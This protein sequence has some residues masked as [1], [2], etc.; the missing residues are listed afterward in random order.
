MFSEKSILIDAAAEKKLIERLQHIL[1]R[2]SERCV[3]ELLESV[4]KPDTLPSDNLAA[5]LLNE[6]CIPN[7]IHLALVYCRNAL[8]MIQSAGSSSFKNVRRHLAHYDRMTLYLM[9]AIEEK[10]EQSWRSLQSELLKAG[11]A[12]LLSRAENHWSQEREI[13][14][15]SYYREM[16]ISVVI[17]LLHVGESGFTTEKK[18]ELVS[19][20]SASEDGKS[21]SARMPRSELSVGLTVED[22]TRKTV[23]WRYGEVSPLTR[24]KRRDIRVQSSTPIHI[25]LKSSAQEE[26]GG[27]VLDIS[28]NGLG[29]SCMCDG[30]FQVG[31]ILIFSMLLNGH[32]LTGKGAVCWVRGGDGHCMAGLAIEHSQENHLRLGNEVLRRQKNLMAE[33]KMKGIP[34]CLTPG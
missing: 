10:H 5:R 1:P 31:D 30:V 11:H 8:L 21:V 12:H 9:K 18:N 19:L 17:K 23:H 32:R 34:D 27:S 3:E 2:A 25:R 7:E 22:V 4:L 13:T 16:P 15:Y 29:V 6:N 28:A 20:L 26:W 14:L 33:L 24:E